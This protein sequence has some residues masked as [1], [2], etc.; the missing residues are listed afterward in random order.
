MEHVPS[1]E[2]ENVKRPESTYHHAMLWS[3]HLDP[4]QDPEN[5]RA[6]QNV[7]HDHVLNMKGGSRRITP[8]SVPND[9]K[10]V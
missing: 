5:H 10:L 9:G 7:L 8:L 4:M 1:V 6:L 2:V 3:Q